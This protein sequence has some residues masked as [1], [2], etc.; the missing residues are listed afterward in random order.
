MNDL[1]KIKLI[2]SEVDG[3]ITEGLIPYDELQNVPYKN[4]YMKDFEAI[5]I[6]K[7]HFIF[8]FLSADNAISY[9][10]FR[11][12]NIPFYWEPKDKRAGLIKIMEHYNVSAEEVLFIGSTYSD[13]PCINMIPVSVCPIDAVTEVKERAL[14]ELKSISGMGVISEVCDLLKEEILRRQAC[15]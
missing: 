4:F 5:N 1:I 3:V 14:I 9:N 8:S 2:V 7:K 15:S 13:L 12:K 11:K 10:L 6:L